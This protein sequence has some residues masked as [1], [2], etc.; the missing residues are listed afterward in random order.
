MLAESLPFCPVMFKKI[1]AALRGSQTEAPAAAAAA[2]PITAYDSQGR[3]LQISREE[4]REKM[5]LPTLQQAW[6]DADELYRQILTGLDDGFAADLTAAGER[7]VA[8][9]ANVDRSHTTLGIVHLTNGQLDA[10]EATL[11]AGME[12]VGETGTLL[13]NLAKVQFERGDEALAEQTLWQAVQ[14]AP[15]LEAGLMWWATTEREKHGEAAYLDALHTAA[16]LPGAWCPQLWLAR[17]HLEQQQV[18]QAQALYAGVLAS[19]NFDRHALMMIAN[20]LGSTGH[21]QLILDLIDPVYDEHLHGPTTG[22]N[23][24]RA[25]LELGRNDRGRAM[26]VRMTALNFPPIQQ[27]LDQFAQ[28]FRAND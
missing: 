10:A 25:C 5:F 15:N 8:I 7:L 13:T 3:E 22:L 16:A 9:D 24:M 6:D 20:D 11:R 19:G 26:L 27:H 2:T 28:A 17:H 12:K 4:W 18:E 21:L 14:A 23:L 1:L